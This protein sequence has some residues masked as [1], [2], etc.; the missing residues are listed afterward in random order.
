ML[1]LLISFIYF[2][3]HLFS[4]TLLRLTS[5]KHHA[6]LFFFF[7]FSNSR[8][9]NPPSI[10]QGQQ[11][12]SYLYGWESSNSQGFLTAQLIAVERGSI[13]VP[14]EPSLSDFTPLVHPQSVVGWPSRRAKLCFGKVCFKKLGNM[15][16]I[17]EIFLSRKKK[18]NFNKCWCFKGHKV[19]VIRKSH[20]WGAALSPTLL[21]KW[22]SLEF[23][24]SYKCNMSDKYKSIKALSFRTRNPYSL[25]I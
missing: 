14:R 10:S 9:F 13:W 12:L 7:F 17:W 5:P 23:Q 15:C 24:W 16:D 18:I 2:V 19:W 11:V 3:T 22:D 25:T 1:T 20:M 6:E 8:S 4:T 21:D